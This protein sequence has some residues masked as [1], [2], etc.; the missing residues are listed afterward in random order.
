L[1][2]NGTAWTR[3]SSR[4]AKSL[5]TTTAGRV[6]RIPPPSEGSYATHHTSP[7]CGGLSGLI[8]DVR[9]QVFNPFR[10]IALALLVGGH[11]PIAFGQVARQHMRAGKVVQ[12]RLIRRRP[13]TLCK[14]A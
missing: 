4:F 3:L 1:L 8:G 9:G 14:P 7:R 5:L 13:M 6:L 12:K 2:V 11:R 10:G